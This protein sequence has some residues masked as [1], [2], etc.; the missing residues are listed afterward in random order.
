MKNDAL[1]FII[2]EKGFNKSTALK[3]LHIS[4][5]GAISKNNRT[6]TEKPGR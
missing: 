5:I 4:I 1:M 3:S 6:V 2:S